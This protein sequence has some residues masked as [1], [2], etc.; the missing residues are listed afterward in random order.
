M[1]KYFIPDEPDPGF[2]SDKVPSESVPSRGD[3]VPLYDISTYSISQLIHQQD[4]LHHLWVLAMDRNQ[5]KRLLP[6]QLL[7]FPFQVPRIHSQTLILTLT[8]AV[9]QRAMEIL[10]TIR[11]MARLFSVMNVKTGRI[12]FA[13]GMEGQATCRRTK[14]LSETDV[15]L[16]LSRKHSLGILKN[17]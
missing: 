12:S 10:F 15:I 2:V 1:Y 4:M 14:H 13:K 16:K 17:G 5:R 9:V 7:V 3:I 11:K 8:A 6:R